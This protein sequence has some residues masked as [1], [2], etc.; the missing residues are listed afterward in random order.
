MHY[1]GCSAAEEED[2]AMQ[3]GDW[4]HCA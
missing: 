1:C 3:V 2:N 4:W